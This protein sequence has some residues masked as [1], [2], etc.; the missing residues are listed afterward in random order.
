MHTQ[1]G[2]QGI[3]E[4]GERGDERGGK[5]KQQVNHFTPHPKWKFTMNEQSSQ[6]QGGVGGRGW[7]E[8]VVKARAGGSRV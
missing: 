2:A 3:R 6:E 7:E 4:G 5:G 1:K 8:H